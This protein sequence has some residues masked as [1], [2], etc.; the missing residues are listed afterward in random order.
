MSE[1]KKRARR[2]RGQDRLV[3]AVPVSKELLIKAAERSYNLGGIISV[4]LNLLDSYGAQE[5]EIAI[6][7][8]LSRDV[9]HPNAIHLCLE[10][11]RENRQELPPI[12]LDLPDDKR[13]RDLVVR[14]HDLGSY[15]HL[16]TLEEIDDK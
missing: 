5:L 1:Y 6:N 10:K 15:D 9:P 7:E 8:A 11:R 4:L 14:T 3:Q 2:A 13:V 16:K 12:S